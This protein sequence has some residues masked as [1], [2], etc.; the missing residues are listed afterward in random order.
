LGVSDY[1]RSGE[2]VSASVYHIVLIFAGVI[3]AP[4]IWF[5]IYLARIYMGPPIP[6]GNGPYDF[7]KARIQGDITGILAAIPTMAWILF[8]LWLW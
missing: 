1:S 6:P 8:V 2:G 7:L 3:G 5:S 4:A